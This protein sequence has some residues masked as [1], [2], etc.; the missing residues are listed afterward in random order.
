MVPGKSW[1]VLKLLLYH[2]PGLQIPGKSI[3]SNKFVVK[4]LNINCVL[5]FHLVSERSKG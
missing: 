5:A 2:F 3:S 4:P 1:I